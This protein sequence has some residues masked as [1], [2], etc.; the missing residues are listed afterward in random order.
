VLVPHAMN[1]WR[2]DVITVLKM[3]AVYCSRL[4]PIEELGMTRRHARCWC[5]GK[6]KNTDT[7]LLYVIA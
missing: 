1:T 6:E 3:K 7:Q 5:E 2:N 4:C